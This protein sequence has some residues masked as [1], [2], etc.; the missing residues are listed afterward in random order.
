MKAKYTKKHNNY[1]LTL[2]KLY[3]ASFYKIGWL[4][5]NDDLGSNVLCRE[6]CF[7]REEYCVNQ[8]AA[9]ALKFCEKYPKWK[10]I[11]DIENQEYL[12][13]V[14]E[15]LSGKEQEP[16]IN[17]Y[18]ALGAKE[19]WKEFGHAPCKVQ[20]AFISGAGK[21]YKHVTDVPPLH[22]MMQIYKIGELEGM[23]IC[24]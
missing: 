13:K 15:E 6:E 8:A 18:G 5:V 21:F 24:D 22:N 23:I 2:G 17:Q 4:L 7:E 20:F 9:Y 1:D 14:W 12:Y 16:W 10:R 19:A 3:D 11:C